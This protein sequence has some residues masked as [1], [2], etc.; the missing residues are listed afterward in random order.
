MFAT[1]LFHVPLLLAPLVHL[2]APTAGCQLEVLTPLAQEE[3][4][5]AEFNMRVNEYVAL[6]RRLERSLPPEQRFGDWEEMSDARN[7]LADAIRDARRNARAGDIFSPGFRAFLTAR[8]DEAL[9]RGGYDIDAVLSAINDEVDPRARP[10][11]VNGRFRWEEVGSAMWPGL[12]RGLP[13][14]P[15]ELEYRFV[16]R[17]LVLIDLHADLVVDI[18]KEALPEPKRR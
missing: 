2:P 13:P 3:R 7:E 4:T 5:L 12:L 10:L 16:N 18:L 15:G 14:L 8:V 1:I 9:A 11:K 17:D 6:H